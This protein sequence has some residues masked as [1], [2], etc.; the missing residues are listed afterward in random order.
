VLF[1]LIATPIMEKNIRRQQEERLRIMGLISETEEKT[2][3]VK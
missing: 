3:A 2:A 1:A